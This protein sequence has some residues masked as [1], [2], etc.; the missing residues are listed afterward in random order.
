MYHHSGGTSGFT[1]FAGFCPRR[2]TALV[3]LANTTPDA[4]HGFLQSAY[5]ALLALGARG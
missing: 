4:R 1:A 3:A 2:G 5:E